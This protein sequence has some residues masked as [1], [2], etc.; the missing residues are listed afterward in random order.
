MK[1][2]YTKFHFN[3]RNHCEE[4][5][6]NLLVDRSTDTPTDRRTTAKQYALPHSKGGIKKV[7]KSA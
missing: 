4:N 6:R 7:V 3:M 2:L 5:I 1:N